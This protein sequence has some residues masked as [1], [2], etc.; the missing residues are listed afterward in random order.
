VA[1][2]GTCVVMELLYRCSGLKQRMIA[3]RFGDLAEGLVSRGRGAIRERRSR[4]NRRSESAF[5]ISPGSVLKSRFDRVRENWGTGYFLVDRRM[6]NSSANAS[7]TDE[8]W[9]YQNTRL[10]PDPCVPWL[11]RQLRL[12]R[13]KALPRRIYLGRVGR[14]DRLDRAIRGWL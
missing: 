4:L 13:G 1:S 6:P 9:K 2:A 5:R 8:T 3:G 12:R 11:A 14:S 10:D 7:P